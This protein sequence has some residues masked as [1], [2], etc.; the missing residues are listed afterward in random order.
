MRVDEPSTAGSPPI[1][2]LGM[3]VL[4][5]VM[6]LLLTALDAPLWVYYVAPAAMA[7][8]LIHE[9]RRLDAEESRA[10]SGNRS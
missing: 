3:A 7:P 4:G 9:L 5:A 8:F 2:W 6:G 10:R 1:F